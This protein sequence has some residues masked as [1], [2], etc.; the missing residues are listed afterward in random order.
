MS[1]REIPSETKAGTSPKKLVLDVI[2]TSAQQKEKERA[3]SSQ[4]NMDLRDLSPLTPLSSEVSG[5]PIGLR[6]SNL[7]Q[8]LKRV[9][10]ES[11]DKDQPDIKKMK[12]SDEWIR[13]FG[14]DDEIKNIKRNDITAI[15]DNIRDNNIVEK[16]AALRSKVADTWN[17]NLSHKDFVDAWRENSADEAL[18]NAMQRIIT[19]VR[20][21]DTTS[22]TDKDPKYKF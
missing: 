18:K 1:S 15:S 11:S 16:L 21:R 7:P 2:K 6:G 19:L 13:D 5:S 9:H 17:K 14:T 20:L 8:E 4:Q 12:M 3:S 22:I 10:S